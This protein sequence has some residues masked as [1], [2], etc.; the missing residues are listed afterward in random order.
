MLY[1]IKLVFEMVNAQFFKSVDG[2]ALRAEWW[3][4]NGI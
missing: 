3:D 2:N 1:I 4:K